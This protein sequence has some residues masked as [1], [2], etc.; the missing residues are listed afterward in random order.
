LKVLITGIAGFV[1]K[2]LVSYLTGEEWGDESSEILGIDL[3][4][5][6]IDASD[7]EKPGFKI[8]LE[9]AD[10]TDGDR[11]SGI[12]KKFKPDCIYHLAAQSSVSYSWKNPVETFRANVFGGVNILESLRKF[13]MQCRT[14]MVCTAEEYGGAGGDGR[15]IDENSRIYPRNPYAISKSALDFFSSV[16]WGAYKLPVLISRSFNHIG[17]GQSERF[18]ASD[19]ARQIALIDRGMQK[20][21][22]MVGNIESCRDFLDVRDAVKAY[23][24][25]INRG[26]AGE[27]Y[28]VCSGGK[29]RI[30]D[31]L[32]ILISLSETGNIKVEIDRSKFRAIDVETIYGDNSK[33]K[34]HTGWSAEYP[35]RKSLED[36]LCYW[37]NKTG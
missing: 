37:K 16:Y 9:E 26:K 12:M 18:V 3:N 1:G 13:S 35:I 4:L 36:V 32:D 23:S 24:C 33:L 10:L 21:V 5:E 19:F 31:L 17:P 6:N 20:P 11:V 22:I 25:I 27:A 34:S 15:P 29:T 8:M 2:H 28:N 14:L 7:Y 30:S